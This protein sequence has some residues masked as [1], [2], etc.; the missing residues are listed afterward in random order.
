[1]VVEAAVPAVAAAAAVA[2][3]LARYALV[4]KDFAAAAG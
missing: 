2:V 4:A 3:V 1:V